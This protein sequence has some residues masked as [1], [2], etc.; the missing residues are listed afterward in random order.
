MQGI[1]PHSLE[2]QYHFFPFKLNP[3]IL[4]KLIQTLI[5]NLCVIS[6]T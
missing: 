5:N 3:F 4:Y 1:L 2:L 6:L